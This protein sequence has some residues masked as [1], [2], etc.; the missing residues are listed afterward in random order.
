M[1]SQHADTRAYTRMLSKVDKAIYKRAVEISQGAP[2]AKRDKA[3]HPE[4]LE[5]AQGIVEQ[6]HFV[7]A[8]MMIDGD[9]A[10]RRAIQSVYPNLPVRACQFHFLQA[11]R[12]KCR[13]FFGRSDKGIRQ[14]QL[15]MEALRQ[16]QRCPEEDEWA[17]YYKIL[18]E[19]V[20]NIGGGGEDGAALWL[21]MDVYLQQSWLSP[22][23]RPL[24]CDYG[25]PPGAFRE[26]AW[27]T[28]NFAESA[29]R[30]FDRVILGARS[31]RRIDRLVGILIL[32]YFPY[33]EL[34]PHNKA[35]PN[36]ALLKETF[37]GLKIWQNDL[38]RPKPLDSP[39]IPPQMKGKIV[40]AY[41]VRDTIDSETS[42]VG[43]RTVGKRWCCTCKMYTATGARCRHMWALSTYHLYGRISEYE[44]QMETMRRRAGIV[45][46]VPRDGVLGEPGENDGWL[47]ET[48]QYWAGDPLAGDLSLLDTISAENLTSKDPG[49]IEEDS[50]ARTLRANVEEGHGPEE[51]GPQD[52]APQEDG[53]GDGDDEDLNVDERRESSPIGRRHKVSA[54]IRDPDQSSEDDNLGA[55]PRKRLAPNARAPITGP[56]ELAERLPTLGSI[57]D[58]S[59]WFKQRAGRNPPLEPIR[60]ATGKPQKSSLRPQYKKGAPD[61]ANHMTGPGDST[62]PAG[63]LNNGNDCYALATFQLLARSPK[64]MA[65]LSNEMRHFSDTETSIPVILAVLNEACGAIKKNEKAR[66][67]SLHQRLSGEWSALDSH[68][69]ADGQFSSPLNPQSSSATL[70]NSWPPSCT[71]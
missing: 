65:L 16:V 52:D 5:N 17:D 51:D 58:D 33:Y 25:M 10:E 4:I 19:T 26:S 27:A 66:I 2:I 50:G 71:T 53:P 23:W 8:M 13:T 48:A 18:E 7:P 57:V 59:A 43:C 55:P 62:A 40:V 12:S 32:N 11:V 37:S 68:P 39:D 28:N 42:F 29:F 54:Y 70:Q 36:P 14:T 61:R 60:G 21:E 3:L 41:A 24:L 46:E 9:N 30:I 35:R 38:I 1:V 64:W 44:A 69:G 20:S 47:E 31:N 34:L 56:G 15:T 49:S 6:G 22:N 67:T 45:E 63:L